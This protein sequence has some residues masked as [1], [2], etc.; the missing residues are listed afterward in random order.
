MKYLLLL[1]VC[2]SVTLKAQTALTFDKRIV[3]SEDK[4]V[5]FKHDKDSTYSYGFIYIDAQAG[6]TFNYEGKFRIANDGKYVPTKSDTANLKI[7][8]QPNRVKI[9]FI[10]NDRFSELKIISTPEWLKYYK[11]DTNSVARLYRWGF[12]YNSWNE[13]SKAL[14]FLE[15][16]NKIEPKFPG[17]ELELAFSYNALGQFITAKQYLE[18]AIETNP[19]ECHLYRELSFSEIHLGQLD[20]AKETY[21]KGIIVCTDKSMKSEIAHNLARQYY[22]SKDQR[23]FKYWARETKKW[24][25]NGDQYMNS[26][27][28]MEAEISR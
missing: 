28:K 19:N 18:S 6:L 2:Y 14:T 4:W 8:L 12:M 1:L 26:I 9:A 21:K 22:I 25:V 10:P 16:A 5:A 24:A 17:L 20:N 13:Y 15:G 7:R 3:E 11:T 27:S 23:N